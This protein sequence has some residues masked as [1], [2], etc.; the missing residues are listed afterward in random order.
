VVRVKG[1]EPPRQRRQ[2]LNCTKISGEQQFSQKFSQDIAGT[3]PE[4]AKP[5]NPSLNDASPPE[6]AKGGVAGTTTARQANTKNPVESLCD[7]SSR[8][9]HVGTTEN[10]LD[11][12]LDAMIWIADATGSTLDAVVV[13]LGRAPEDAFRFFVDTL[14]AIVGGD[15]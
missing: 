11:R 14:A 2:N 3:K 6:K 13:Q 9:E 12:R 4:S 10:V 8:S 15:V 7:D 1:L 5:E